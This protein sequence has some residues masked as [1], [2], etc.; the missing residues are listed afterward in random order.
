MLG[1]EF[2]FSKQ[3]LEHYKDINEHFENLKL[4]SKI[5]PKIAILEIYLRNALDY[6]L[7][8]NCKE[9]IKTSDNPF[10]L[11][12]I[13][14]FKDKESLEPHQILSRLSLGVVAKLIISYKV[15]NKILDL[16]TFDFRKYSSSNRNFFT[17]ESGIKENFSNVNKVNIVLNL[18]HTL[19]NRAC[20]FE[21]LLKIGENDNKL[22]PR[23]STKEKRN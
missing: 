12:K 19:R 10:L 16:R 7:S 22:Y 11:A 5:M 13:N 23:I 6:E 14:E 1:L 21:N 2:I 9:W 20:H 15:Q 8:S 17:Y 18:L 4:I 3:R